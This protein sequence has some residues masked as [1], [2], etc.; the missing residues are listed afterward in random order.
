MIFFLLFQNTDSYVLSKDT[1]VVSSLWPG[2]CRCLKGIFS[3][4]DFLVIHWLDWRGL[5]GS[6]GSPV[7][8]RFFISQG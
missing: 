8:K 5:V 4:G 3:P 7:N 2:L 6:G 1:L